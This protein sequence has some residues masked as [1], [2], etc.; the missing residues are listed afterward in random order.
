MNYRAEEVCRTLDLLK[1]L[2]KGI[3]PHNVLDDVPSQRTI[4][5]KF[6]D[7]KGRLDVDDVIVSGHS[8]GGATSLLAMSKRAEFKQGLLYDPWMYAIKDEHLHEKIERPLIF[9]NTWTF[10]NKANVAAM[11]KFVDKKDVEMYT[12]M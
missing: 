1:Q 12:I 2:N 4:N 9:V 8:F 6:E 3:V 7:L 10:H 11:S 5:F